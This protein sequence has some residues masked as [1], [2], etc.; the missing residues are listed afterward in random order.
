[1]TENFD[2]G[3]L[4]RLQEGINRSRDEKITALLQSLGVNI[5]SLADNDG[6]VEFREM[7]TFVRQEKAARRARRERWSKGLWAGVIGLL[8]TCAGWAL[9]HWGSKP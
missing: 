8:T 3:A 2:T 1:M 7:M 6:F 4:A 9:G 5:D